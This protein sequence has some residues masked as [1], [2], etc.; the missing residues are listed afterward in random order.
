MGQANI[1]QTGQQIYANSELAY[2]IGSGYTETTVAGRKFIVQT[3]GVAEDGDSKT[4][5]DN[6]GVTTAIV[7]PETWQTLNVSGL[8]LKNS[9]SGMIK[10]GDEVSGLPEVV[11]MRSGV[12]W[13]VESFS[14]DWA[15]EDVAKI[16]MT[17]RGYTF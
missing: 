5:K 16:S 11:G 8:L 3:I 14:T 10:K 17:V 15:N 9:G 13:R 2:G 4:Y 12:K 7:I 1:G 6:S